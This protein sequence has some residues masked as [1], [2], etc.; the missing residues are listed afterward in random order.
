[1]CIG[2]VFSAP[3]CYQF[4]R[5]TNLNEQSRQSHEIEKNAGEIHTRICKIGLRLKSVAVFKKGT[6]TRAQTR[7]V[8]AKYPSV[9][10]SK[11]PS[12]H[13]L[14]SRIH[15]QAPALANAY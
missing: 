11:C 8:F 5:V 1:M 4:Q 10:L 2:G 9:S 6:Q 13:M 12:K 14:V 15:K 7:E 3:L